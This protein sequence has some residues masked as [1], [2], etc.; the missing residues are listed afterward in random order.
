MSLQGKVAVVT[1]GAR[2][3]G[4]GI[5]TVLAAKGAAVAVWDL[6]AEGAEKTAA[7]IQEA[8]GRAIAIG[9]D[10][11]DASDVAAAAARTREELGPVAILVNNAGTTAYQPFTDITEEAWDRMIGI[12]LKG[13]FL[14][15][16]E[17]LPDMLAA[18]WGRIVNISSSSAQTGAP[19]MAHYVAS[20]G[21]VIGLTRALA[22]EYIGKGITVNHVPPGFIDTPLV[23]QGP[24]DVDAVAATMPMKRAGTPEDVAHAVAY[25]ASEEAGYVTGQTL[26]TNGGRYLA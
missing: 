4:Q 12:N 1:G 23:R 6:N 18:G 19:A 11:S 13:P 20:K 5:A 22:V 26:S 24:V 25:L 14:V 7:A 3:I 16:K 15:T 21:G 8:G 2:G 10:A 17:L 9:G